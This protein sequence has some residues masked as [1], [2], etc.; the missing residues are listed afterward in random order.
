VFEA[1]A[2][3]YTGM[4]CWSRLFDTFGSVMTDGVGE[5]DVLADSSYCMVAWRQMKTIG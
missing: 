3:M 4:L 5:D 2:S 1:L